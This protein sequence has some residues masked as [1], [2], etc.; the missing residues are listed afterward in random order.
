MGYPGLY[1]AVIDL[2][3]SYFGVIRTCFSVALELYTQVNEL[4]S[5]L[6]RVIRM[7]LMHNF[8]EIYIYTSPLAPRK[9]YSPVPP[10]IN[11]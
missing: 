7:N 6:K 8:I 11:S 4:N 2:N 10:E 5:S 3:S 1:T 9:K